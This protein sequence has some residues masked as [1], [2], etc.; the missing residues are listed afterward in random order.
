MALEAGI[1]NFLHYTG[2]DLD[3]END[4][5]L[6]ETIY[7]SKVNWVTTLMLDKSFIYP[8]HPEWIENTDII[9]VYSEQQ[10]GDYK[11]EQAIN[12]AKSFL[13]F[14]KTDYELEN[15]TLDNIIGFQV[16]DIKRLYDNGVNIV[17]GTD[18]GNKYIFHGRSLHE[19]MQLL[20]LGGMQ[21]I[22]IIKMGTLNAAKMLG[23]EN[24]MGSVEVGKI[25]DM[26]LLDDNPLEQIENTLS[27]NMV[28]KNGK[29][30]K[31]IVH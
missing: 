27:I 11:S 2:V 1:T 12:R 17:L 19:E 8:L 24:T 3:F 30:Q 29:E 14:F 28:I 15:P 20:E 4:K 16:E 7:S 9:K 6:I 31:R 5:D 18:T 25:A 21:P 23:L 13:E 26:V 10:L 22:D